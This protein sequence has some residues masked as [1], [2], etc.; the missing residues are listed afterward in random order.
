MSSINL[1]SAHL[2]LV[3]MIIYCGAGNANFIFD[4]RTERSLGVYGTEV[5]DDELSTIKDP[6]TNNK[7]GPSCSKLTMSL[8]NDSLKF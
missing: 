5:R 1:F 7:T 6:K 2:L 8:V 3:I 4:I